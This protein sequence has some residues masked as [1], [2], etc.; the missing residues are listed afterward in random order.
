[1]TRVKILIRIVSRFHM[2]LPDEIV[3]VIKEYAKP[4]GWKEYKELVDT[5]HCEWPELKR[6]L[7]DKDVLVKLISYNQ[8]S[9]TGSLI[10]N[11]RRQRAYQELYVLVM[12]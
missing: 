9:R 7:R 3:C 8:L 11:M 1:M 6:H 10:K 4:Y 2:E 12:S 5:Q